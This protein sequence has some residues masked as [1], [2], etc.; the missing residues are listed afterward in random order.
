MDKSRMNILLV[1][2]YKSG[3]NVG[4]GNCTCDFDCEP[5]KWE[6]VERIKREIRE[7]FGHEEPTILNWLPLSE[8][9]N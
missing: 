5:P 1:Y 8:I 6:D 9:K 2:A 7:K 3:G 4:I